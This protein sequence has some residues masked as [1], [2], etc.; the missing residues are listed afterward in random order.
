MPPARIDLVPAFRRR[1]RVFAYPRSGRVRQHSSQAGAGLIEFSIIAVPI[2]LLGLGSIEVAHWLLTRQVVSLALLEAG[3]AGISTHARPESMAQAFEYALLPLFPA[4][5]GHSARQNQQLAFEQRKRDTASTPWKI[6]VLSPSS[7]AFNDFAD[8]QLRQAAYDR[9]PAIN[10]NY[11]FEQDQRR[12]AS[13]WLNGLGPESKASIYQ[14]N[15]LTLQLSYLHKPVLPGIKGLLRLLGNPHGGYSQRALAHGYLPMSRE[16][17]LTMQSHPVRW[18][19]PAGGHIVRPAT[20]AD[21]SQTAFVAKPCTGMWCLRQL[22]AGG[23]AP[24][25]DPVADT[26]ILGRVPHTEDP[27][28]SLPHPAAAPSAPPGT[29]ELAVTPDDPS[30]GLSLCCTPA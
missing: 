29:T 9:L 1:V 21:S 28:V 3:R 7:A 17:S 15:T 26:P 24:R 2:L 14:A 8:P 16:I 5:S 19:M 27:M 30:C 13:G 18:P 11:Q 25:P 12:R 23:G 10:N 20:L 6:T 4:T 22:P